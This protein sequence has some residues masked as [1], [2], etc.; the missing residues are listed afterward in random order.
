MSSFSNP[1]FYI[2]I[3]PTIYLSFTNTK[4]LI[5]IK[6][7]HKTSDADRYLNFIVGSLLHAGQIFSS[8]INSI[9][10]H[11]YD[12]FV[13]HISI[14]LILY[15][16]LQ[17]ACQDI[18]QDC[19][20]VTSLLRT[21]DDTI[22]AASC[23]QTRMLSEWQTSVIATSK[24]SLASQAVPFLRKASVHVVLAASGKVN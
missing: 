16:V 19:Q 15:Y 11:S 2:R 10:Y 9:I 24:V 22:I 13:S 4:V 7:F 21:W 6:C 14:I 18:S 23:L 5:Q 8:F 12:K 3:G 17:E 20:T 1:S